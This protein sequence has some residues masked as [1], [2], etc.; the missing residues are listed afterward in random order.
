MGKKNLN[1][2]L[3]V[4]IGNAET[5]LLNKY[6]VD[7]SSILSNFNDWMINEPLNVSFALIAHLC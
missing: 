1:L 6:Y 4:F 7:I 5:R 2:P 3:K